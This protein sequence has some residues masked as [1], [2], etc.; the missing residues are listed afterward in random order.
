LKETEHKSIF[1]TEKRF[2]EPS[3]DLPPN[4]SILDGNEMGSFFEQEVRF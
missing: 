1:N 2:L 3:E 4:E